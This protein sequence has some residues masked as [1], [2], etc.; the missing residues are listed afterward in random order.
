MKATKFASNSSD[1]L[2][3]IAAENWALTERKEM[4][5]TSD[6]PNIISKTTKVVGLSFVPK[7]DVF[8]F[9]PYEK[10]LEKSLVLVKG[11]YRL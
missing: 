4:Q 7:L 5:P 9:A 1:V 3:R 6:S 10:L 8:T 2:A 11:A